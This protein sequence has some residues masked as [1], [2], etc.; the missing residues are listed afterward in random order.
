MRSIAGHSWRIR[1]LAAV[2]AV[3]AAMS[4][5]TAT[6][7]AES[8]TFGVVPQF[9]QR[10]LFAVWK[11]IIEELSKRTG[12]TLNLVATLT[13]PEFERELAKG[14][15][16]FVY[17]NPYHIL[18]ESSR[19]GY[20]PLVRDK[21]ALR[22]ILVVRKDSP[23]KSLGELNG[24]KLAIPSMNALGASLL[25]RAD[26]EHLF[27]VKMEPLNVKTHSSVYLN[28][29]TG[30]TP[31]GGGVE[32]TFQEQ[33]Q[34]IQD[35]LRVLYTTRE[36]PSHP[37]A[38]HPRLPAADRDKLQRAILDMAATEAGRALLGEVPIAT[39]I[40]TSIKDYQSMRAW[41]LDAYWAD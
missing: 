8:Y 17:A 20:I 27:N 11:P 26:L 9:E 7:A 31:A 29:V 3:V 14:S 41:G 13:V 30:L 15:F 4:L 10:K 5:V 38:G 22:G 28:V 34:S 2:V 35:Q 6:M 25:M 16:D 12:L 40:A 19:Q 37:V 24:M 23:I 32:K 33:N 18:R 21:E 36:M 39:A 1:L